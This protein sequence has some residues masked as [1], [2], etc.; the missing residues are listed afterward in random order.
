MLFWI[1]RFYLILIIV[2]IGGMILHN[3]LDYEEKLK[4]KQAV[5]QKWHQKK[6]I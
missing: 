6:N 4:E 2:I 5:K 1:T 3:I